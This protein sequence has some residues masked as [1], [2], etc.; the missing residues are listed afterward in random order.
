MPYPKQYIDG[1]LLNWGDHLFH[2]PLH[3]IRAPRTS[4]VAWPDN[5]AQVRAQIARTIRKVPEVM[6]KITNRP[7][8]KR[9]MK[10]IRDHL[11]YISRNGNVAIE[12]QDGQVMAGAQQMPRHR[13][14]HDAQA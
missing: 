12:D 8:G 14:T 10:A 1:V 6:V 13:I 3:R 9:G 2:E 5:A 7:G 4:R 11:R